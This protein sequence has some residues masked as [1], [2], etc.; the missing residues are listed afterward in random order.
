MSRTKRNSQSKVSPT[1]TKQM[2]VVITKDSVKD[3]RKLELFD[4]ILIPFLYLEAGVQLFS[5]T[6]KEHISYYRK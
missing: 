6:L 5:R 3:W 2:E 1:S 4:L